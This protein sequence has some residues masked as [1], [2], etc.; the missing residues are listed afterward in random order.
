MRPW[1]LPGEERNTGRPPFTL[2]LPSL[3]RRS[4][5]AWCQRP[6]ASGSV[7]RRT[8]RPGEDARQG[9][10]VDGAPCPGPAP[11]GNLSRHRTSFS[12]SVPR[13][14][15]QGSSDWN[16]V[17]QR[18][19]KDQGPPVGLTSEF[20]PLVSWGPGGPGERGTEPSAHGLSVF[21]IRTHLS[22]ARSGTP[23]GRRPSPGTR[24][25]PPAR[26]SLH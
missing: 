14:N 20:I 8:A 25:P 22:P 11:Y 4:A 13:R 6:R 5:D 16:W 19:R 23:G 17:K 18:G 7:L 9:W 12:L 3:L 2:R 1:L 15:P 10:H 24:S 21:G 26:S